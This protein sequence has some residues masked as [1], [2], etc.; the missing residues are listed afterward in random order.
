MDAWKYQIYFFVLNMISHSFAA[1]TYEIS[2]STFEINLVFP[3]THVL[4][5]TLLL[6]HAYRTVFIIFQMQVRSASILDMIKH[7]YA[8]FK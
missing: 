7:S 3:R 4:F 5:S 8:C 1:L 2:C 6:K